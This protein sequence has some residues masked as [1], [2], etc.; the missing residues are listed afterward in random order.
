MHST[1]V[2]LA[3]SGAL[4]S[5]AGFSQIQSKLPEADSFKNEA[6]VIE[7]SETI[8]KMHA[9]GT[10]ERDLHVILRV[11]SDGA[12]Q[13]FGVLSFP[14]ASAYETPMIKL[15][16]VQK[17]DGTTVD[18]P[19]GEAIDMAAAV[20]REAPLY[21]D[22]KEKH[23]P[24]RSLSRGDKLE[25][26]VDTA[27]DKAEAPGQFWGA[28]H[29]TPPGTIV[30][31]HEVL[32]LEVPSGKYA[33]VWSPNH[34]PAVTD[35]N[36]VKTYT[37]DVPQLVTAPRSTADDEA[38]PA[39]PKDPDED[40]D[41]R[42]LPSVAWTTFHSWAEVG[43]WYRGLAAAQATPGD[44]IKARADDLTRDAKTPEEQV[45]TLYNYVS[46]HTRY[47]G[48]DFGI[49]RYQP[50]SAAEVLANQYGDCKDKDTLLE[51]L[52]RAKGFTAAPALIGAGIAPIPD[53][54]SPAVFNHVITTVN[55]PTGRVWLDSTPPAAPYRYL[56]QPIR[57]QKA[58]VIPVE[59]AASLVSTPGDAP[60]SFTAEFDATG[61]LDGEGKLTA[62]MKSIY[63]DDDEPILRALA[64][65]VAPAEWDKVSQYI[66][67]AAGFGGTTS[68]TH[69]NNADDTS[70]PIELTYDYARHP[71]GDWDNLR[72]LPLFPSVELPPLASDTEAPEQDIQLGA[73][74]TLKA[75]SRIRLPE[76]YRPDL[77]DPV[78]AKTD[79][80]VFDKTYRFEGNELI[81][82]REI[83]I[84]KTKL[85]K[86][87]W[88]RYQSFSKDISLGSEAW[89][90]LFPPSKTVTTTV[91]PTPPPKPTGARA[92]KE[93][94]TVTIQALPLTSATPPG[95]AP[96]NPASSSSTP[97]SDE[98]V[99]DLLSSA[100]ESLRSM[101]WNAAREKLDRAKAKS[102]NEKGLWAAYAMLA[103]FRDH[104][105]TEAAADL[106]KE[107]AAQPDNPMVVGS[108][109]D[110]QAKG[111]D[112]SGARETVRKFL[113][114]HPDNLQ[115]SL[116][117]ASLETKANDFESTLKTLE[118]AA[119]EHPDDRNLR[120]QVGETLISLHR[121]EEAAAAAKSALDGA[122]DPMLLNNAAYVLSESGTSL[123]IAEEASRKSIA[124]FEEE[125]EAMT[126]AQANSH[127]FAR[128]NLLIASWDTLGWILFREGKLDEA[129]PLLSAAWRASLRAEIGDH[130]GQ[131][132]EAIGKKNDALT[133][134]TLALAASSGST[135]RD[136][137]DHILD[138]LQR[139]KA[140]G[141]TTGPLGPQALQELRT[142]HIPRPAGASG[143]GTFR[144][145]VTT[146]GVIESQQ[147]SGEQHLD[148]IKPALNAMK[149]PELLPP[150]SKAHLL[151]SAVIS[152]SMGKSCDVVLVPEGGLQTERE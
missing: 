57:D 53:L 148:A 119:R 68:N 97:G 73:L 31:L 93:S 64:R 20:S 117:L 50:H 13:E 82:Q 108:L 145:E 2:L 65:T 21:S 100:R 69:F 150:G 96:A 63:R 105:Y 40:S 138:S 55:M 67:A 79:F 80:A 29:F 60:Y 91:A 114:Q 130:L 23:L 39:T 81:T 52:L 129:R 109:A 51:A 88:K 30:I 107:L 123:D 11:Q 122:D 136:S 86:A 41:G 7:R 104:N 33:Q 101:D 128:A 54:P 94:Q 47:V 113:D 142:Y 87:D 84:L 10:G 71:F 48:I 4:L 98:S 116:Y 126:T 8:Y 146:D 12:A 106:R 32:T 56:S 127:A 76:G 141:A 137:R 77:P 43:D 102:P 147:M 89:V 74:R 18:T 121:N 28:M 38:K 58:L 34:K 103:E 99:A 143:W 37:W 120:V 151:R 90:Q 17:P 85:P 152:C 118:A 45:R 6:I 149:F 75:V 139:L 131:I 61:T 26:E 133:A 35:L 59:G 15:V 27:I 140:A 115:L 22:V 134:Y 112:S 3:L 49:G 124:K 132:D 24:V 36:G 19:P 111:G 110:A 1:A 46:A 25:Y 125:S 66:S 144:L 5:T 135:T 70:V 44:A 83:S 62:K 14:F 42:K 92:G 16:R 72:I 95:A 78:H 9:D